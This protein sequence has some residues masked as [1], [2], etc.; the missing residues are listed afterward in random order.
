MKAEEFV[1]EVKASTLCPLNFESIYND[2]KCYQ[3]LALDTLIA[4]HEVCEKNGIEYQ[5]AYGSLLGAIRDDGQIPWDYDIDVFVPFYENERLV[6]ALKQDLD[7][8]YYLYSP[9]VDNNCRHYM[10]RITP[11]GYRSEALHVDIFNLIGAPDDGIQQ[12]GKECK[13]VFQDRFNK[14]VNIRE[15]SYGRLRTYIKLAIKKLL[16]LPISDIRINNDYI[17]LCNQ[18]DCR[19]SKYLIPFDDD[20]DKQVFLK[21]KMI[22]TTLLKTSK[23][24]F[25]IPT[26]YDYVLNSIYGDYTRIPPLTNRLAELQRTYNKLKYYNDLKE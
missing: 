9:A 11:K 1:A 15:E 20:S 8:K 24:T 19:T 21:E 13:R 6:E 25:R 3:Q 14:K 26:D 2:F 18:Y 23:G 10:M 4:F 5:L 16:L 12:F 7:S 17:S 22:T